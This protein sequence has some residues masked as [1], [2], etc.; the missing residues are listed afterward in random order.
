MNSDQVKALA[1]IS[2]ELADVA[3]VKRND[4]DGTYV[5]VRR[6]F[7]RSVSHKLQAIIAGNVKS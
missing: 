6:D 2:N 4:D 7:L 5:S 1:T 3:T